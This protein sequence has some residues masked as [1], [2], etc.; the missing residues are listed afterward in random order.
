VGDQ[1]AHSRVTESDCWVVD[2]FEQT[3]PLP[4]AGIAFGNDEY[5][6]PL[7]AVDLLAYATA[8]EYMLGADAWSEHS[9]FRPLLLDENP[10][11]GKL[12]DGEFWDEAALKAQE[13]MIRLIG[14]RPDLKTGT[15]K[16]NIIGEVLRIRRK[17]TD[18]SALEIQGDNEVMKRGEKVRVKLLA[19]HADNEHKGRTGTVIQNALPGETVQVEF[20]DEAVAHQFVAEDL[21]CI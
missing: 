12:Y 6:A 14:N 17:L 10:A 7:Q 16:G 20:D 8:T 13:E 11:Y 19:K 18:H 15:K 4:I 5:F 21:E 3:G 9:E 2:Q 1:D